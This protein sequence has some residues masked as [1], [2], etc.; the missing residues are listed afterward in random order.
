VCGIAHEYHTLVNPSVGDDFLD[1]SEMDRIEPIDVTEDTGHRFGEV[2][3][4]RPKPVQVAMTGILSCGSQNVRIALRQA[5][6]RVIQNS[7]PCYPDRPSEH[8]V[9]KT[10]YVERA[11]AVA[12]EV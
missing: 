7:L 3:E 10:Q 1:G 2:F 5:A 6:S 9:R 4:K 11:D 12:R 8:V